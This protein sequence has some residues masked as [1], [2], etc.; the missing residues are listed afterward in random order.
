MPKTVKNLATAKGEKS[1]ISMGLIS[2]TIPKTKVADPITAPI[3]SPKIIQPLFF[4]A[5]VMAKNIS[6]AAL[7]IL[8]TN[9]PIKIKDQ[10]NVSAK[11]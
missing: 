4:L 10:L 1:F 2:A 8:T 5:Q 3:K 9:N 11:Y 7:P 6:G